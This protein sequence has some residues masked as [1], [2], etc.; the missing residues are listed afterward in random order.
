MDTSLDPHDDATT[1]KCLKGRVAIITGASSGLGRAIALLFAAQGAKLV[2][3]ADIAK[4]AL[5]GGVD[6]E[7]GKSTDEVI[8]GR[9][10]AERGVFVETDVRKG[11]DV[12]RCVVEAVRLGGRLD[13][14]VPDSRWFQCRWWEMVGSALTGK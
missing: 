11:E 12:E 9:Y 1:G 14:Y 6:E 8:A 5:A 7:L 13:M 10:G 4:D 3:C 2:V